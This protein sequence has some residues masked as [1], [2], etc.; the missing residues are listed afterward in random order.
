MEQNL[1]VWSGKE[2]N[3]AYAFNPLILSVSSK[4]QCISRVHCDTHK[5]GWF[6]GDS[7][8]FEDKGTEVSNHSSTGSAGPSRTVPGK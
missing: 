5:A 3:I 7:G 4:R 2:V 1:W 8:P 6:E